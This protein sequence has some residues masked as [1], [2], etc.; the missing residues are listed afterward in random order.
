M[1]GRLLSQVIG[2]GVSIQLARLLEPYQFG[3]VGITFALIG[4]SS[5]FYDFG[6][7]ASIIQNDNITDTQLSTIFYVNIIGGLFLLLLFFFISGIL[8]RFYGIDGLA[9]VIKVSAIS[10][11]FNAIASLPSALLYK[12]L[13]FKQL[14]AINI[15]AALIAGI[16]AV[17]M[18]FR[19]FGVWSLVANTV[20]NSL[21]VLI[22]VYWT[23]KWKPQIIFSFSSLKP[24]W[25]YGMS[26][27]GITVADAFYSRADVFVI[28]KI[29]SPV[30]LGYYTRAQSM[31]ALVK[32]FSSSSL[33]SVVF[34]Y[35]S[36]IKNELE[37][38]RSFFIS[39]LH[40]IGFASVLLSGILYVSASDLFVFLFTEKWLVSAY[41]FQIIALAGFAYPVSA[42]MV[43]VLFARGNTKMIVRLEII[44]KSILIPVFIFGFLGNIELFLY[45]L[46][47][48]YWLFVFVNAYFLQKEIQIPAF[49][50]CVIVSKYVLLGS[51]SVG[52]VYLLISFIPG[53]TSFIGILIKSF[54][55]LLAYLILNFIAST[56]GL[57]FCLERIK[58]RKLMF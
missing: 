10:F 38:V 46:A 40:L 3:I 33:V 44:K 37:K 14:A 57:N 39:S 29:F 2:F 6:L 23:V 24:L 50:Q 54:L 4:F 20:V 1:I 41:Y 56:K 30:T 36:A 11:L 12:R 15:T 52:I 27:F 53:T 7:K 31:D 8:E 9:D 22:G 43:N 49:S 47:A 5:V 51:I 58:N 48:V 55:F 34:P 13:K 32:Q 25:K 26:I 16:V 17:V 28:G 42:L 19:G 35:F 21:I 18:A 45:V